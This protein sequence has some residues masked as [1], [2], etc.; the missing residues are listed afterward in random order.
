MTTLAAETPKAH[1]G[2]NLALCV[3]QFVLA[4]A[5]LL[6]GSMK[7]M[8]PI[9]D[10]SLKMSWVTHVPPGLVR[11]IGIS[12]LT[13]AVGL[14]LPALTRIKPGLT[15]L[16]AAAL[17]VVMVMA[18]SFHVYLGEPA[19]MVPSLVL[20]TIA[21]FVAWGRFTRAPIAPRGQS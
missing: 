9:A 13:G 21:A 10:L 18:A 17:T 12:E 1:R 14:L 7:A 15:T 19:L 6:A 2:L 11:F 5:Y 16:A 20:G 8:Q 4:T 3:A